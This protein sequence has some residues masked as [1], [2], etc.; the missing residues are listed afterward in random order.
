MVIIVSFDTLC[1][2]QAIVLSVIVLTVINPDNR[3]LTVYYSFKHVV[4]HVKFYN[5][6]TSYNKLTI[7]LPA[8]SKSYNLKMCQYII[9]R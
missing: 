7:L 6:P 4:F 5:G 3:E 1:F 8:T 2:N 9:L